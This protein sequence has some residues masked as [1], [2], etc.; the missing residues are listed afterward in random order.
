[1]CGAVVAVVVG[2]SLCFEKL[3][4]VAV[5]QLRVDPPPRGVDAQVVEQVVRACAAEAGADEAELGARL[6]AERNKLL[7]EQVQQM[8]SLI[9]QNNALQMPP[10]AGDGAAASTASAAATIAACIP[11][12]GDATSAAAACAA[13]AAASEATAIVNLMLTEPAVTSS[14]TCR[15]CNSG[16]GVSM[17]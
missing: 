12:L 5:R 15:Q 8:Q 1:M 13:V 7:Q 14:F 6:L 2:S 4:D 17:V 3:A 9:H 10:M 11:G 16:E